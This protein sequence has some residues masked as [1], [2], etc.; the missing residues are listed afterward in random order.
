MKKLRRDKLVPYLIDKM[1]EGKI[2]NVDD[3]YQY[4]LD[5]SYD[6]NGTPW[7]VKYTW[8]EDEEKQF[9]DF[10][11][12]TLV[13]NTT[14]RFTVSMAEKEWAYFNLMYGLKKKS[15]DR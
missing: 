12:N 11:V 2:D 7:F 4:V 13:N 10:F 15:Y 1:L 14:P 8:S 9:K 6:E 5:N 3:R